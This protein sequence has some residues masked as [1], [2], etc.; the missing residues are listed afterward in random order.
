MQNKWPT[1]ELNELSKEITVGF[2]GSMTHEY[3]DSGIPFLRS[4]NIDEH[5][6]KW[7]DIRYVS[8]EFHTK[9]KKS[10]LSPGDVAIVRTGKPGT[11]CVIPET[12]KE[13]NC[14]DLVIVRVDEKRLNPHFLSYFMNSV[15]AGQQVN[16][17][18]VGAVQQHFNVGSAK[19]IQVPNPS[20]TEQDRVVDVL[21]TLDDKIQLNRQTNQTLENMA[22][23]LFKS[24]FVNFDPVIDNALAAGNTIP[25]PLQLSAT[26]RAEQRKALHEGDSFDKNAPAPLPE[27]IRQLFPSA[28]VF[29]AEMG[30]IPEG[31]EIGC[32]EDMLV[33]QRGFDLPKSKRTPGKYPLMVTSG[34]DGTHSEF[35]VKGPGVVTGRSGKLG[36]VMIVQDDFWPLNTTLWIKEYKNSNPYHAYHLLKTLGLE[37]YNSG[38]A[39]PTL[40]RNHVHNMRLLVPAKSVVDEYQNFTSDFFKKVRH[41]ICGTEELVKLRDTLLPKL[42]SGELRIPEAKQQTEAAVA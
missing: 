35:K 27:A 10:A 1:V 4:K 24:W 33:L 29:D 37:Q 3:V 15:A 42:I 26:R 21:K 22:Q 7:D 12:L 16:S 8:P 5:S 20:I 2:V 25:E 41:N 39:V 23:A 32:L 19:K 9:L 31:W 18:V 40:N 30:W 28:F 14:S 13:A 38:S 36:E 11:T 34:Q 17:H 6:L